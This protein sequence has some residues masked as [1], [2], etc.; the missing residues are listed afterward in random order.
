MNATNIPWRAVVALRR[1]R[2]LGA[3]ILQLDLAPFPRLILL[4]GLRGPE[5]DVVATFEAFWKDHRAA[6]AAPSA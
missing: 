3:P 1:E 6:A 4:A 2:K 5:G